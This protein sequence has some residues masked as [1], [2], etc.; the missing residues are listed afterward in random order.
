MLCTVGL[1]VAA[2]VGPILHHGLGSRFEQSP[3]FSKI[4]IEDPNLLGKKTGITI[5]FSSFLLRNDMILRRRLL[6]I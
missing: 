3:A 5:W 6:F 4:L 1:D 2:H